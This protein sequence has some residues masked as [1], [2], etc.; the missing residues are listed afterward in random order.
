MFKVHRLQPLLLLNVALDKEGLRCPFCEKHFLKKSQYRLKVHIAQRHLDLQI[1]TKASIKV[2]EEKAKEENKPETGI[3]YS[4]NDEDF[5]KI[6]TDVQ[7][8]LFEFLAPFTDQLM[9][10]GNNDIE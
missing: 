5:R 7:K 4:C 3:K 8:D 10:N 1:Q 9:Q 6:L 2:E